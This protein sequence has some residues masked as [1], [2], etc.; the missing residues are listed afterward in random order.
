VASSRIKLLLTKTTNSQYSV[1]P[2][3]HHAAHGYT[4]SNPTNFVG[5]EGTLVRE[6]AARGYYVKDGVTQREGPL[7][8]V[9]RGSIGPVLRLP[10]EVEWG[11]WCGDEAVCTYEPDMFY[12]ESGTLLPDTVSPFEMGLEPA[13]IWR[14]ID[15]YK[16]YCESSAQEE[17]A[18]KS[19]SMFQRMYEELRDSVLKRAVA[20]LTQQE[21][22]AAA[23]VVEKARHAKKTTSAAYWIEYF[24]KADAEREEALAAVRR[25]VTGEMTST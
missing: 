18:G 14:L 10:V 4:L 8:R 25:A 6:G 15:Y 11:G 20:A 22:A 9:Q 2:Q 12:D 23:A 7:V 5:K 17:S 16:L 21:T 1:S 24:K 3:F 19:S 13:E